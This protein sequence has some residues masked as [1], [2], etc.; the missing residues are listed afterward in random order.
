MFG[1]LGRLFGVGVVM[2]GVALF[3]APAFAA[4]SNAT[5]AAAGTAIGAK[6]DPTATGVTD[7][8]Q[9]PRIRLRAGTSS[10]WAGY[11]AAGASGAY[12]SVAGTWTQPALRCGPQNTY[13]AFWVGLD[14]DTTSTVEQLGTEADCIG[15]AP[16]YSSWWEMYPKGSH[17]TTVGVFPGHTYHASVVFVGNGRFQLSLQDVTS[18]ASFTTVQ[19]LPS[20]QRAS[21]EAIVEAPW[22]GGVLPLSNFGT[23]QFSGVTANGATMAAPPADVITMTNSNGVV[24]AQPSTLSGGAFSVNWL[25]AS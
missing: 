22:S 24:K 15:G 16:Q 25:S 10:N 23:A 11:A 5:P 1:S 8:G 7:V 6:G 18:G 20:A 17:G 4:S 21:A 9:D 14:G 13:S 12:N 19:R 2:S 3:S